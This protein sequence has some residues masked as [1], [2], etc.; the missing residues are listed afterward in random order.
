[1]GMVMLK[2]KLKLMMMIVEAGWI[3]VRHVSPSK[4]LLIPRELELEE[5][6]GSRLPHALSSGQHIDIAY[7]PD[8][9]LLIFAFSANRKSFGFFCLCCPC[10]ATLD[11][12]LFMFESIFATLAVFLLSSC[13]S[14]KKERAM[15]VGLLS[16]ENSVL[17]GVLPGHLMA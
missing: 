5:T 7:A 3:S 16:Y 12:P 2:L 4:A 9:L 6:S 14:K 11:C 17:C 15:C 8:V 13:E 1:M 10:L